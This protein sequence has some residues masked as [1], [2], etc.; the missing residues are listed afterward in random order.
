MRGGEIIAFDTA[1]NTMRA[2]DIRLIG[3]RLQSRPR[4]ESVMEHASGFSV[5]PGGKRVAIES[6]G[7]VTVIPVNA[8]DNKISTTALQFPGRSESRERDVFG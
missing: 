7:E 2:L 3:D 6:R 1:N 8:M 5:A 4:F